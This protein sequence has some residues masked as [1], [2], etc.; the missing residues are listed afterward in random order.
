MQVYR[1][2]F[3]MMQKLLGLSSRVTARQLVE[4]FGYPPPP[5]LCP[6]G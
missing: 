2:N 1:K 5:R 3:L 6:C 4:Q